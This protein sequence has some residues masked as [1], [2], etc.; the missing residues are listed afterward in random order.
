MRK[1]LF[2]FLSVICVRTGQGIEGISGTELGIGERKR[3]WG[4]YKFVWT[5]QGEEG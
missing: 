3:D 4:L 5:G 1:I 2:S